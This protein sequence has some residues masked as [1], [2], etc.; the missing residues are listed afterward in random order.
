MLCMYATLG[1]RVIIGEEAA[2]PYGVADADM[3]EALSY[4]MRDRRANMRLS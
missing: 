3:V 2:T 1:V 4:H